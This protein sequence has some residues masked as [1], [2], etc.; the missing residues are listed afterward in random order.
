[1]ELKMNKNIIEKWLENVLKG[2]NNKEI[3]F[4]KSNDGFTN[5]KISSSV[6]IDFIEFKSLNIKLNYI[7]KNTIIKIDDSYEFCEF[8]KNNLLNGAIVILEEDS[9]QNLFYAIEKKDIN[10]I[11]V[12]KYI[13]LEKITLEN[14]LNYDEKELRNFILYRELILSKI[15]GYYK[16]LEEQDVDYFLAVYFQRKILIA[17]FIQRLYRLATLNFICTDKQIGSIVKKLLDVSSKV[18]TPKYIGFSGSTEKL[19]NTRVYD[20]NINQV[21]LDTKMNI[22]KKLV[23]LDIKGLDINEISKIIELPIKAIEKIFIKELL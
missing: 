22:A 14:I 5:L 16:K 13:Y 4:I 7:G 2:K 6:K 9:V 1:M 8:M 23:K 19:K 15:N 12:I 10:V 20:L 3:L 17:K 18:V 21:E 11:R